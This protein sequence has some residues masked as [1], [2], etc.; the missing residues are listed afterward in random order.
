VRHVRVDALLARDP[1]A[2]PAVRRL[3]RERGGR[4][5]FLL[6][7]KLVNVIHELSP[8]AKICFNTRPEDTAEAFLRW[9]KPS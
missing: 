7:E 3:R 4:S 1:G 2:V 6:F 9:V 8:R 5:T